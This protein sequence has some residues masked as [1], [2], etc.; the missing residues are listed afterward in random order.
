MA[1]TKITDLKTLKKM[2]GT[3]LPTGEWMTI[4]QEMINDFAK[5]TQDF[6]WLHVD[7]EK[8]KEHSPFKKPIAHGFLSVALLSKL[9]MDL[10]TVNSLKMG[11]NYGLNKVRFPSPV[12][13]DSEI[14]LN[15]TIVSVEPY[16]TKA[17]KITWD[18]LIEIKG[19]EKPACVAEFL[20]L[21]F[22]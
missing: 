20:S 5:A 12:L 21:M 1:Q 7:I 10:V 19:Q 3:R 11:V 16:D 14:R 22:E 4:T 17:V 8:I 9:L 15:C 6:Q 2:E 18:C 13:V